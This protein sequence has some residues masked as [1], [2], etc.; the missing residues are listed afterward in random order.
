MDVPV[1]E[2]PDVAAE[3]EV[4]AS[5]RTD[6]SARASACLTE[7]EAKEEGRKVY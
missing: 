1:T 7:V 6:A 5:E 4:L 3:T 2:E